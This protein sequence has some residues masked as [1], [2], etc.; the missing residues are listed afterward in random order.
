MTSEVTGNVY[1]FTLGDRYI[2]IL[3]YIGHKYPFLIQYL[4]ETALKVFR[5]SL[6]A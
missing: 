6:V 3:L 4:I 1:F 2:D 5:S